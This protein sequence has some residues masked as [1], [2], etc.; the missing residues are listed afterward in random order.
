[1][2]PDAV[3]GFG[4]IV[5][6]PAV[7]AGWFFRMRTVIHEQNVV[8]GMATR[9]LALCADTIAVSFPRTCEY[10]RDYRRKITVTGNPL[11]RTL[12]VMEQSAARKALGLDP[13]RFTVLVLGGSQGAACIN[14]QLSACAGFFAARGV[15]IMH[16]AG[17]ADCETVT[18]AYR[19]ENVPARVEPFFEN[20]AAAYSAA[21][22]LVARAGAL[23]VSEAAW[24]GVPAVYIPYPYAHKHQYYNARVAVE[25][26]AAIILDEDR[27]EATALS[28]ALDTLLNDPA[29]RATMRAAAYALAVKDADRALVEAALR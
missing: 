8:P 24:F 3:V 18:S 7:C 13:V 2:R 4:S 5:S 20:M 12:A 14:R 23:T 1:M 15:Q 27:L 19:K 25:A 9:V 26:G 16:I 17:P 11:R 22:V 28:D 10:M 21:D 29:K 6:V